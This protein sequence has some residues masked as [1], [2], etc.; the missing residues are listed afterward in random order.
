MKN[1]YDFIQDFINGKVSTSSNLVCDGNAVINYDT[2]IARIIDPV[3]KKAELNTRKYS[4]TTSKNQN[5]IR[6]EL[7]KAGYTI[8]EYVGPDVNIYAW[9]W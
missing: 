5:M 2:E 7:E 1:K 8:S 6:R 3:E 4:R 9:Y